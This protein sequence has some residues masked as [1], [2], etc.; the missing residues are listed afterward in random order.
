[1]N[2]F[3]TN[4]THLPSTVACV[5]AW[6]GPCSL[7]IWWNTWPIERAEMK[8]CTVSYVEKLYRKVNDFGQDRAKRNLQ[9]FSWHP[10]SPHLQKILI[11]KIRKK[12]DYQ[13]L[14]RNLQKLT[15]FN[16]KALKCTT[17]KLPSFSGSVIISLSSCVSLYY[18]RLSL[19]AWL[20]IYS[21]ELHLV[22]V[23]PVIKLI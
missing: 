4:G 14:L 1:M 15:L 6:S 2:N 22:P 18:I 9:I 5:K 20:F 12:T 3:I 23:T 13:F 11:N 21:S 16:S 10:R 8:Q 19:S 17:G 7:I